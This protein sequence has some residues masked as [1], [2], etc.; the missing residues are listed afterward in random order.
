MNQRLEAT[1]ELEPFVS[2]IGAMLLMQRERFGDLLVVRER[3][4]NAPSVS[5]SGLTWAEALDQIAAIGVG[6][7]ERGVAPG[8]RVAV[9]SCN[10]TEMMLEELAVMGIGAVS[11][12]IFAGYPVEQIEY[13]LDHSDAEVLVV[14]SRPQLARVFATK[15]HTRLREIFVVDEVESDARGE[16]E[17]FSALTERS[18]RRGAVL[19]AF[20]DRAHAVDDRDP[21]LMMYTSGTTGAPKGVVL[22]HRNILSQQAALRQ[23][24]DVGPDDRLLSY[25][26]WHH[27]FGGIFERFL[28]L[29]SGAC[30]TIDDS[31]GKDLPRLIENFRAVQP[32]VYFSTP[33]IY[34]ELVS[35]A[36]NDPEV[37]DQLIHDGLK[38]VFTAAAPLPRDVSDYFE[39]KGIPVVEGWGLTE[40]SPC[41]T[42]TPL[43]SGRKPGSVGYPLAG[44]EVEVA[45]DGE[46]LVRGPNVMLHYHK[47][48]ERTAARID[49]EAWLHTGD[50]GEIGPDGLKIKGRKDGVF[51]LTNGEKVSS[52]A[53]ELAL[54]GGC[55]HIKAAVAVGSGRD[56]V[57]ALVVPDFANLKVWAAAHGHDSQSDSWLQNSAIIELLVAELSEANTAVT[58]KYARIGG[59]I[60]IPRDLELGRGEL[61][62]ST[63]TVRPQVIANFAAQIDELYALGRGP[64]LERVLIAPD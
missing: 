22:C 63:K 1:H 25:L 33:R 7:A 28:A 4:C 57:V 3:D 56:Y 45:E 8:E 27:S 35:A 54:V 59:V 53:V 49:S 30:L 18:E 10:R 39:K 43:E 9:L 11:V 36:Q 58:P 26:P 61:T 55:R 15:A 6:L 44:V 41:C 14:S 21:C 60:V 34:Q 51:K 62:P 17:S 42:I 50:L 47:D 37:E 23:H 20:Y 40:T 16:A 5:F 19:S 38:F 46:I 29:T 12:P 32:T 24:W 31:F 2:T 48:A 13:I 52:Q 64:L